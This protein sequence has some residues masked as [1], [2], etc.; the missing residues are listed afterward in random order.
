M[1]NFFDNFKIFSKILILVGISILSLFVLIMLSG[2]MIS[3]HNSI[4]NAMYNERY[5]IYKNSSS[6][7]ENMFAINYN[8]SK[9]GNMAA[10]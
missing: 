2:L 1:K 5:K 7:F 8:L 3:H 6:L 9:I 4:M 10:V